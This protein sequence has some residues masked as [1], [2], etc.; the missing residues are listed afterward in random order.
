[1]PL[2]LCSKGSLRTIQWQ[3]YEIFIK[4]PNTAVTISGNEQARVEASQ[5]VRTIAT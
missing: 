4:H 3:Q 5:K 2:I 1:M